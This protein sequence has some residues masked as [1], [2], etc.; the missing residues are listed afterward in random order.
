MAPRA[1]RKPSD[2]AAT[3]GIVHPAR[4]AIAASSG[5]ATS[6]MENSNTWNL[7]FRSDRMAP[8]KPWSTIR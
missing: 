6:S 5:M 3:R 1:A 7:Q 2:A 8:S 4:H